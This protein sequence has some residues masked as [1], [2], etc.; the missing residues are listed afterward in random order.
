[1]HQ[2]GCQIAAIAGV[3]RNEFIV[4]LVEFVQM[5]FRCRRMQMRHTLLGQCSHALW[6][7]H[8]QPFDHAAFLL[9]QSARLEPKNSTGQ[10]AIDG[11]LRFFIVHPNYG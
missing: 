8:R 1:M 5:P 7:N 9:C 11:R 3:H 4:P 10:R 2:P 6:H